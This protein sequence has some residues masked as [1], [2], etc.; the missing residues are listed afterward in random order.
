MVPFGAELDFRESLTNPSSEA[1]DLWVADRV[2]TMGVGLVSWRF[3][4]FCSSCLFS[5]SNFL[6]L[7]FS[8]LFSSVV[9]G[10]VGAS[11]CAG[12]SGASIACFGNALVFVG[13]S[14][15]ES[16]GSLA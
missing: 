12:P 13:R 16:I 9:G 5:M 3:R 8:S 6:F 1:V 11:S 4:P 2:G 10:A 7:S 14:I 15:L